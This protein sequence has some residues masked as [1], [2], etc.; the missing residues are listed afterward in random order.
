MRQ[1]PTGNETVSVD[2]C[3]HS[4]KCFRGRKR[5]QRKR[6]R[7]RKKRR[8]RRGNG[9]GEDEEQEDEEQT[10]TRDG[11]SRLASGNRARF[12]LFRTE[13]RNQF[14]SLS[15]RLYRWLRLDV[16]VLRIVWSPCSA[17]SRPICVSDS[18]I[19]EHRFKEQPG[20]VPVAS[21]QLQLHMHL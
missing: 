5:R 3:R 8:R 16:C 15:F 9:T 1:K 6:K 13:T 4:C 21:A 19:D 14:V 2:R 12:F 18:L 17:L 7:W 10:L 20:E 11:R